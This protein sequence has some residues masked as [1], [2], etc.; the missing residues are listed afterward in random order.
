MLI[1]MLIIGREI[2]LTQGQR[3]GASFPTVTGSG[4][5]RVSSLIG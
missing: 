3:L 1:P 2:M 5:H 4:G